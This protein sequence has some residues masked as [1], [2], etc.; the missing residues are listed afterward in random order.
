MTDTTPIGCEEALR[1]LF[2]YLDDEL[3]AAHRQKV[4]THLERC[5]SCFSRAEF[6]RRLKTHLAELGSAPLPASMEARIRSLIN[7]FT[8]L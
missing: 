3:D 7:N 4:E 5:R 6:E 1:M 8:C 2:T